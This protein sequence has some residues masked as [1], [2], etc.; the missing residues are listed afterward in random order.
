MATVISF[1]T[2]KSHVKAHLQATRTAYATTVDGSKRQFASDAEIDNAILHTDGEVCTLIANTLHHPYQSQFA[3]T[4]AALSRGA[5]LPSRNGMILK[6]TGLNGQNSKSVSAM[7]SSLDTIT[8]TAH[9]FTVGQKIQFTTGSVVGGGLVI[10]TDYYVIVVDANTIKVATT[11]LNASLGTAIDLNA[12]APVSTTAALQYI[13]QIKAKNAD[14]VKE[15]VANADL[16]GISETD[17]SIVPF[18][19]IE[20]SILYSTAVFSTVSYTEYTLTAAPQAPEP[21]LWAVI[22]GALARLYKDGGDAEM[23][24]YYGAIYESHKN[25]IKGMAAAIPPFVAYAL[26]SPATAV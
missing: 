22:S 12:T 8:I 17:N 20:G 7:D 5:V 6:V 9:G 4:S 15:A 11:P 3:L 24:G 13:E 2:C 25:D 18:F 16:F 10:N 19:F 14:E 26:G 21:L 23:S 1:N